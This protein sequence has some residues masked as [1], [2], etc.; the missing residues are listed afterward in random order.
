MIDYL[1]VF[2]ERTPIKLIK[3]IKPDF[4]VKG[5]DYKKDDVVGAQFIEKYG[6]KV[7]IIKRIKKISTSILNKKIN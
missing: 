7:K 4:L 5:S 6:G 3:K 2:E 1:I